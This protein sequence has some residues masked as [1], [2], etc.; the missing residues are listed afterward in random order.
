[1]RPVA[2]I[3]I[4]TT[5]ANNDHRAILLEKQCKTCEIPMAP[6]HRSAC[7]QCGGTD[8]HIPQ[9]HWDKF[10][11]PDLILQDGLQPHALEVIENMRAHNWRI[12]FLT[13]RNESL[14]D[15]TERWLNKNVERWP[16]QEPCLMRPKTDES[17][18]ASV[19]KERIFLDWRDKQGLKNYPFMFFEDDKYVISMWQKY[20]I[21]FFCPAAWEH[22]NAQGLER[23]V[24]PA[25][26]R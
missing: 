24:E 20:G 12:V 3:D 18:P 21:V 1:M 17:V 23:T 11:Q 13:G 2:I 14:R 5:I 10:L 7:D 9:G 15:V 26:N 8:H 19:M 22:M 25:W 4:D 16:Q 6:A